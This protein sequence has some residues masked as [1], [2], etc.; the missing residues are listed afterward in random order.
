MVS[1]FFTS[2][3]IGSVSAVI[4]FLTTFL[5]YIIIISLGATLNNSWKFVAVR[6]IETKYMKRTKILYYILSYFRTYHFRQLSVTL[7]TLFFDVNCSILKLTLKPPLREHS[8]TM[9][10]N[11]VS[12]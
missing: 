6:Y 8:L 10:S 12:Q 5:P 1:T 9:I 2:A 11:T 3:S 7:G 4:L